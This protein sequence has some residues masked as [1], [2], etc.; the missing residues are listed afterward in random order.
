MVIVLDTPLKQKIMQSGTL[1]RTYLALQDNPKGLTISEV[2]EIT[3]LAENSVYV[4]GV[5]ELFNAQVCDRI[6]L[7]T[8][9]ERRTVYRLKTEDLI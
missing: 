6:T 2:A 5:R 3:G 4:H 9:N 1:A 8:K 7:E